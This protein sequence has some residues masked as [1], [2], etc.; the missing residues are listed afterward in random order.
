[1]NKIVFSGNSAN[2]RALRTQDPN[3]SG[4]SG[5]RVVIAH[6]AKSIQAQ[7]KGYTF[8]KILNFYAETHPYCAFGCGEPWRQIN[9]HLC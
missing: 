9:V 8:A 7:I 1:M 5:A 6:H 2:W 4:F 3:H